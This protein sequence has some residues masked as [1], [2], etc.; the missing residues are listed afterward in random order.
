MVEFRIL[1]GR[2]KAY[3]RTSAPDTTEVEFSLFKD[4]LVLL[5]TVLERKRVQKSWMIFKD[6]AGADQLKS[7]LAEKKPGVLVDN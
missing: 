2:S 5:E 4:L 7:S 3:G 6:Q 1:R